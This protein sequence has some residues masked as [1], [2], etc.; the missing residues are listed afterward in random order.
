MTNFMNFDY[1]AARSA[2]YNLFNEGYMTKKKGKGGK[3]DWYG[4]SNWRNGCKH[5]ISIDDTN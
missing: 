5:S 4:C 1:A 2:V 3:N